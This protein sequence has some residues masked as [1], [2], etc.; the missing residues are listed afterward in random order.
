M[1]AEIKACIERFGDDRRTRLVTRDKAVR[2]D[3]ADTAKA[4]EDISVVLSKHGWIRAGKG[5][6]IDPQGLAFR[7]G[8]KLGF[9][10]QGCSTDTLVF[11]SDAGRCYALK[12]EGLP[13]IRAQGEPVTKYIDTAGSVVEYVIIGKNPDDLLLIATAAGYGFLTTFGDCLT[14]NKNGKAVVSFTE[15]DKLLPL[16]RVAQHSH[17]VVLV[18][19]AGRLCIVALDELPH[20]KKGKG[21]RLCHILP[22]DFADQ[23]DACVFMAVMGQGDQLVMQSGRR[24]FTLTPSQWQP[25]VI[26][27]A[28]RGKFI[29]QGF[30]K[31]TAITIVAAPSSEAGHAD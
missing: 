17:Y 19:L 20:L 4:A 9:F 2:F 28:K 5:H 14:K 12:A 27:R 31:V 6:A 11:F 7:T 22:K 23:E 29:P 25:Y 10:L 15:G 8:D 21:V 3:S 30:R 18:T 1:V 26:A 13:S 24:S 16:Q